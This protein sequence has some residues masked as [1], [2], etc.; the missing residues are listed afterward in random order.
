MFMEKDWVVIFRIKIA[1]FESTMNV[2]HVC[3]FVFCFV[4]VGGGLFFC[5]C[6]VF[7][8]LNSFCTIV[9]DHAR[10]FFKLV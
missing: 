9:S 7:K 3:L 2:F 10:N 1:D 4:L 5:F 6:F 8:Q